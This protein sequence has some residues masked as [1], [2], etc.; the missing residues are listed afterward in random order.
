MQSSTIRTTWS[1][2]LEAIRPQTTK[3]VEVL[4]Y[5]LLCI[6]FVID[7]WTR[8]GVADGMLYGPVLLLSL[9]ARSPE[10]L[11]RLAWGSAILV[12]VGYFVSPWK[13]GP[14][15]V[16]VVNRL[17]ALAAIGLTYL[18]TAP[19][20]KALTGEDVGGGAAREHG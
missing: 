3:D 4:C 6:V 13:H 9:Q 12:V 10:L 19:L 16:G 18:T 14:V 2:P 17:L 11:R 8:R 1:E 5:V 20:L 7:H 15:E